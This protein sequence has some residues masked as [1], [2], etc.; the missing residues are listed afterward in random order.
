METIGIVGVGAMGSALLERLRLVHV[1]ALAY[2][3]DP[4]ALDRAVADRR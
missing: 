2:D 1:E 4:A 3:I